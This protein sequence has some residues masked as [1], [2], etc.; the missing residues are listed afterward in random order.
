MTEFF[1]F[2]KLGFEHITDLQGYDHLLFIVALCAIFTIN[3][4][5]YILYV[6]TFFTFGHSITLALAAL[7][8][9]N[10][11][12]Q[13]I[14][15]LIPI[16]IMITAISNLFYKVPEN[17][18]AKHKNQSIR[19]VFTLIFGLIH[20]LGFSNYLRSLLGT[21]SNI[22]KQLFAFNI[23]LELGQILIVMIFLS[24]SYIFYNL[25]DTKRRDINLV[26]SAFVAGVTLTILIDKWYF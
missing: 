20:G 9:V 12:S 11:S 18:L 26:V 1:T 22:V 7:K 24:I 2:L 8:I 19:Y 3:D 5:K 25:L 17:S 13:L 14:E 23:G 15:F 6:I 4:W 10:V 21:D 16:T